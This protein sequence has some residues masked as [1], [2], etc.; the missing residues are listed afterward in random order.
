MTQTTGGTNKQTKKRTLTIVIGVVLATVL[1]CVG[2]LLGRLDNSAASDPNNDTRFSKLETVTNIMAEDFYFGQ[3]TDS[4]RDKLI[5]DALKG[6]VSAQGDIHTEYMTPSE[7]AEFT[8]ALESSFVGIGVQYVELDGNIFVV[9]VLEDSPALA[10]GIRAGDWIVAID[11]E[12][13][14][15]H[16]I[17]EMVDMIKG[18][19]G[20]TVQITIL[21]DDQETTLTVQRAAMDS[22]VFSEIDGTTGILTITSFGTGTGE[23]LKKHLEKFRQA[24]VSDLIIDL[25][26]NGGGYASTLDTMCSYF[27]DNGQIV[28]IEE[29]RS[30]RQYIDKVSQSD[31]YD[32][33]Q[34]VILINGNSASCS[35][36]FTMALKENCGAVTVG[37]TSYGKGIAQVS[38]VFSDG[39]AIKYT[40]VIW[41]SGQGVSIHGVGITPDV[42][43]ELDPAMYENYLEMAQDEEYG[44]DSVSE[45][46]AAAQKFLHFLN[47]DVDRTDGYFSAAT[48]EALAA[49][50]ADHQ[51]TA[52]GILNAQTAT[53]LNS[54]VV[55]QWNVE[56]DTYDWQMNK[57]RELVHD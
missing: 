19:E 26:D 37:T 8:G 45:K 1:Y 7:V 18:E 41:K 34:I 21:R 23:E 24:G 14:Q 32:F 12:R 29:D 47:Y 2:Y 5:D 38:K 51:L 4:Y 17:D 39:S 16:A 25:R 30:G 6:M 3:D 33:D 54:A 27:M 36:V 56:R 28:M 40:D 43:V 50:Q 22:T 52:D 35:E 15:D 9:K 11:G 20:S 46:T 53:A 55:W 13:C 31:K 49:F 10:A 44:Y 42:V 48:A 57:A